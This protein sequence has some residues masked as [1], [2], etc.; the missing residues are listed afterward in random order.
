MLQAVLPNISG[1]R[2]EEIA[3]LT[4][5]AS[6]LT[7]SLDLPHGLVSGLLEASSPLIES[8]SYTSL[9]VLL[10]SVVALDVLPPPGW[11]QR[12]AEA[13]VRTAASRQVRRL[14]ARQRSLMA[15]RLL[16]A[17]VALGHVPAGEAGREVWEHRLK[18]GA[19]AA[20]GGRRR[21][22]QQRQRGGEAEADGRSTIG[23]S[24]PR[25]QLTLP[26]EIL[27]NLSAAALGA[28]AYIEWRGGI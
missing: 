4:W 28:M 21:Q 3:Q 27:Q 13:V 9:N 10:D 15:D 25:G 18:S 6:R 16:H 20:G 23:T 19:A 24:G 8:M 26:P 2:H 17:L 7:G 14:P 12:A 1:L 5:V 22:Q 11:T